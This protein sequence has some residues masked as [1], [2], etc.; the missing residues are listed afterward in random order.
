VIK[1]T[2]RA[3]GVKNKVE[4]NLQAAEENIFRQP[5]GRST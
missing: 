5:N 2:A 1:T 4:K 3:S